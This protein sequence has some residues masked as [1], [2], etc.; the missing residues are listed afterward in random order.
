MSLKARPMAGLFNS[1]CRCFN[2]SG[3][4]SRPSSSIFSR[5]EKILRP[6]LELREVTGRDYLE[7]WAGGGGAILPPLP[8]LSY[9]YPSPLPWMS[10]PSAIHGLLFL[11]EVD[12]EPGKLVS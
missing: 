11:P 10:P 3:F 9:Y 2:G 4:T 7:Q 1:F 12:R 5:R 6:A 8:C